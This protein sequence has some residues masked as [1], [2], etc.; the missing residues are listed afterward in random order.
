MIQ[1]IIAALIAVGGFAIGV[2][3]EA[4]IIAQRDAATV[5]ALVAQTDKRRLDGDT[6]A[7]KHEAFKAAVAIREVVVEKEV[8]RVVKNTVYS[9]ICLDPDGLRIL[10]NDIAARDT[11]S[12][13]APTVPPAPRPDKSGWREHAQV[14]P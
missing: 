8:E 7:E 13:P 4:G 10:A 6:A 11:P 12:Q 3:W 5:R 2:K 9:N 14:G 1:I